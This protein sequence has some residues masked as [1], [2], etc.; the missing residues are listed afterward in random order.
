MA[1]PAISSF[2][3]F[4]DKDKC[5]ACQSRERD[6]IM[7]PGTDACLLCSD[8]GRPCIFERLMRVRGPASKFAWASLLAKEGLLDLDTPSTDKL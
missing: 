6:C 1:F 8:A 7:K 3:E 2:V 4:R 5:E